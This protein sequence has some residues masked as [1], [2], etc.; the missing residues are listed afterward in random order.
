MAL[1][2]LFDQVT[3]NAHRGT[4]AGYHG[5]CTALPLALDLTRRRQLPFHFQATIAICLCHSESEA[6][7]DILA[8]HLPPKPTNPLER[9]LRDISRKHQERVLEF[10]RFPERNSVLKTPDTV[11]EE[12][13]LMQLR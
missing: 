8:S 4:P 7:Q 13:F 1:I 12:A 11:R 2:I 10:G 5:D 9:A 6:V 3:R